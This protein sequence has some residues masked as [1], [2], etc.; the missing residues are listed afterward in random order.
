MT[1]NRNFE[2]PIPPLGRANTVEPRD[3]A[4]RRNGWWCA[5][6]LLLLLLLPSCGTVYER[7]FDRDDPRPL[8]LVGDTQRTAIPETLI[9]REQNDAERARIVEAIVAEAPALLVILGDLVFD[10]SSPSHWSRFD[11]LTEPI[12]DADIPV[13]AVLGNHEYWMGEPVALPN[14]YQRFPSLKQSH[15]QVQILRG[16]ALVLLDSNWN[17]AKQARWQKQLEWYRHTLEDL[18]ADDSVRGVLVLLHHP[19]Y[20]NSTVTGDTPRVQSDFVSDFLAAAKTLAMI[21]GHSHAYEH[22]V[23]Q[24]RHFIVSGGGGGP[25]VTLLEGEDARHRDLFEG[26]SPR[27]FHYLV[28]DPRPDGVRISARGFDKGQEDLHLLESFE[29]ASTLQK[30]RFKPLT[31]RSRSV[32]NRPRPL[33]EVSDPHAPP[34]AQHE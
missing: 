1:S 5:P 9:G 19:P 31:R 17:P 12:R 26:T 7:D 25:R 28:V 20:S 8:V 18:D 34:E 33:A 3:F 27:P 23:A 11:T 10:G 32:R 29:P 30:S 2:I 21:S 4:G 15:W 6:L 14:A 22:F 13:L 24:N 16:L